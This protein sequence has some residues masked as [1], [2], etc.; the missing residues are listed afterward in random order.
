MEAAELD[1]EIYD[2]TTLSKS[3]FR[4]PYFEMG[5]QL[6]TD[7]LFDEFQSILSPENAWKH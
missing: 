6:G 2:S 1:R 5:I 7:D 4:T 3:F